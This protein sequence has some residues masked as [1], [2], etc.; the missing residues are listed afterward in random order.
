MTVRNDNNICCNYNSVLLASNKATE[1]IMDR[2]SISIKMTMMRQ[3]S[4]ILMTHHLHS[5][6]TG[7]VVESS[8]KAN[9]NYN[10]RKSN[11]L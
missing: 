10:L 9:Q 3:V 1:Y 6:I 2:K 7:S 4:S 5:V 8:N 11:T